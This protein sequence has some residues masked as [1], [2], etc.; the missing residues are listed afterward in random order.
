MFPIL[1]AKVA[2]VVEKDTLFNSIITSEFIRKNKD[3]IIVIT[4]RVALS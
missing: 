4:V 1:T 2:L 3:K